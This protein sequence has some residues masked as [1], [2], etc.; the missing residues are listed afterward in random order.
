M[1]NIRYHIITL[2]AVFLALA[3]GIVAGST[4]IQQSLVNSLE[5]NVTNIEKS[6]DDLEKRNSELSEQVVQLRDREKALDE[7]GP[8]QLL[9]DRLDGSTV[10]MIG[11]DGID[12]DAAALAALDVGRRPGRRWP[13]P[14]GSGSA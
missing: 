14:S 4:V 6:L 13:A 12:E 1:I 8:A 7:Q 9:K 10:L 2:V 11:V 5:T 3:V